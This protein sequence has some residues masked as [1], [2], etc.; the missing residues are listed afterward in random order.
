MTD[1]RLVTRR[2][3]VRTAGAAVAATSV[4]G[5]DSVLGAVQRARRR[6]AIVGTGDRAQG[7]WGRALAQKYS[8]VLEFV[9]LCDINPKRVEVSRQMIGVDCPTFTDFDR[10]CDTA[11]PDLLMVTTVDAF[12][13]EYIVK[14]LDRGIDVMTEKPMVI[15]EQQ[16]QAVL[17]AEARA[18]RKIVVTFNY[19]YAPKHQTMKEILLSGEIG[20]VLSVDF[21]WYLDVYHGADYFRRW[22]RLKNRGG[23]LWVHKATHHFDLVNWWLDADPVE[24]MAEGRLNVYGRN[25]RFRSTHCRPCPHKQDCRFHYDITTNATRMK[26]YVA[27]EDA[28]G[29]HRDGCVFRE[30]VDIYDTMSAVV[31]YSNGVMMSYSLNAAM[32]FEGYRVAFN[33]DLGRLEVRDHERQPWEVPPADD[34]EIYVTKSFGQRRRVAVQQ[35]EGGHGGGDDRLRDLIFRKVDAPAHMRLPDSR[36]GAMSCLTGIAARKSVEEKRPIRI[37]DLVRIS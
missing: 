11:K 26:L 22:H 5:M 13:S 15:N 1:T 17:D 16:C 34:T 25:G 20:R 35:G 24:V 33:G 12:H 3:F 7:M 14:G 2:E 19:R 8:D 28:D 30:D 23:S 27:C 4:A 21:A 9:G 29:Y 6:Y 10:M 36:A 31:K 32:P 18:K 37:A